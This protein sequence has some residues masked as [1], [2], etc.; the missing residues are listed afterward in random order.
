MNQKTDDIEPA[1]AAS[2]TKV[3]IRSGLTNE[4]KLRTEIDTFQDKLNKLTAEPSGRGYLVRAYQRC[5][6]IRQY[7]LKGLQNK[8]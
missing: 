5:I 1:P 4:E 2:A 7:L 6:K 8:D 3:N